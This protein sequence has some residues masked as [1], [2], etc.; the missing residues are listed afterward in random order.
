M[1]Y[2]CERGEGYVFFEKL[3][4]RKVPFASGL[5]FSFSFNFFLFFLG[6]PSVKWVSQVQTMRERPNEEYDSNLMGD[7]FHNSN[8]LHYGVVISTLK[9][10][11]YIFSYM[12]FLV[13]F[14]VS[15]PMMT[16]MRFQRHNSHK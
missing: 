15:E 6:P 9:M 14:S 1:N 10:S 5:F 3:A 7:K 12:N 4:P 16:F 11:F 2:E 13:I 8:K